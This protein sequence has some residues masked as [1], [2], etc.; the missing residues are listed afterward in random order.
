MPAS[1]RRRQ[2]LSV[3]GIIGDLGLKVAPLKTETVQLAPRVRKAG[4]AVASLLRAQ[5]GP[6]WQARHLY[7]GAVL[8]IALYGAP[9]WAPQLQVS[10]AAKRL[11]RQALRPLL[12]RA[13]REFRT[14]LYMATT[15]LAGSPPVELLAEERYILYWKVKELHEA[16]ELTARGLKALKTQARAWRGGKAY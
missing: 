3:V 4:T 16:G 12:I 5:G 1:E 9:I 11:L 8:S 2:W 14:V 6:G 7:V 13:I 10:A 15:T